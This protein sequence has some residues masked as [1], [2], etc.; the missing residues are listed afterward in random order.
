MLYPYQQEQVARAKAYVAAFSPLPL[1]KK[2][3]G[4]LRQID[5]IDEQAER[6][7][8]FLSGTLTRSAFC[9]IRRHFMKG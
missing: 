1:G 3:L 8:V 9:P 6:E 4:G 5:D 2:R 7:G